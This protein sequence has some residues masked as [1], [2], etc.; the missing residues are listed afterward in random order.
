MYPILGVSLFPGV[1]YIPLV[2]N[3][4]TLEIVFNDEITEIEL[5]NRNDKVN[6]SNK[7]KKDSTHVLFV[8][9]LR[10]YCLLSIPTIF[11]QR[12]GQLYQL[13]RMI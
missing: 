3:L 10:S 2:V 11:Q 9:G 13:L 8:I 6:I 4:P 5:A 7:R 12:V 1:Q